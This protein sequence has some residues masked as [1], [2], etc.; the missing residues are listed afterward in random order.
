MSSLVIA[1]YNVINSSMILSPGRERTWKT[2]PS[3][4]FQQIMVSVI[5]K[6]TPESTRLCE[7]WVKCSATYHAAATIFYFNEIT[8][9]SF[10]NFCLR[11]F[12]FNCMKKSTF[13]NC[14]FTEWCFPEI[15]YKNKLLSY[16]KQVTGF[17]IENQFFLN[18]S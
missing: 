11:V 10:V 1:H 2:G 8:F 15:Q 12:E 7:N 5:N 17:K 16:Y 18:V 13:R 4:L 14:N 9:N 3:P 6:V